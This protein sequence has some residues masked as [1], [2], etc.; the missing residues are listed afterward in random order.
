MT[1]VTKLK[2]YARLLSALIAAVTMTVALCFMACASSRDQAREATVE[3]ETAEGES[4]TTITR[5]QVTLSPVPAAVASL[6][7]AAASLPDL[8]PGLPITSRNG[9]AEVKAQRSGDSIIITATCDSLARQIEIVEEQLWQ[10]TRQAETY[11]SQLEQTVKRRSN[12]VLT[13]LKWL[14]AGLAAGV[15]LTIITPKIYG[16]IRRR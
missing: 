10:M 8:P 16:S 9:R 5:K 1:P 15:I 13:A 11:K 14:F 3:Q 7:L 6:R 2:N 4:A 12:A